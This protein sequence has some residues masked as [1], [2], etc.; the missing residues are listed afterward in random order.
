MNNDTI[1]LL[2]SHRSFGGYTNRYR[3]W[4]HVLDCMMNFAVYLP[5]K[6]AHIKDLPTLYWLSGLGCTEENFI[7][8]SGAQRYLS[9]L[10]LPLVAIDTSPRGFNIPND[11]Q[12]EHIGSGAG[13]YLNATQAPWARNYRMYDY[14][15]DEI[16]NLVE[17]HFGFSSTKSILGHSMG[18]HGALVIG[19]RNEQEFRSISALAPL[20][21]PTK[22]DF[23]RSAFMAYLGDNESAWANYDSVDLLKASSSHRPILIDQ[24]L[25]D[26]F[27]KDRLLTQNIA[28]LNHEHCANNLK[29]RFHP[30]YDHSYYFVSSF[31]EDHITFHARYLSDND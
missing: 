15:V 25:E 2:D 8:K 23:G 22:C 24:G 11:E 30:E 26:P 9:E 21:N 17:S 29:V 16:P 3:H 5:P 31:I 12:Q 20:S 10:S 27:L 1:Q 6:Y 7:F 14:I 19:L 13:F 4:S 28:K 18:G